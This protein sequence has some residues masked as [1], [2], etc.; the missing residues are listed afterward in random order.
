M[1]TLQAILEGVKHNDITFR[2]TEIRYL[3]DLSESEI[4]TEILKEEIVA[5]E[6]SLLEGE[7]KN[8]IKHLTK[9]KLDFFKRID[10]E[11]MPPFIFSLSNDS[12]SLPMWNTYADNAMGVAIGFNKK[13]L[14][15]VKETTLK[16]CDYHQTDIKNY[17]KKEITNIYNSIMIDNYMIGINGDFEDKL[18]AKFKESV[19][20]LKHHAFE[21]ENESRL[22]FHEIIDTENSEMY[23]N[24]LNFYVNNG[25]LKPY[26][27]FKLETS[28]IEEIVIG[29]CANFELVKTSLFMMLKKVGLNPTFNGIEEG[30]IKITQSKCPFRII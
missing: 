3:N 23:F 24:K 18:W 21:Y 28:A 14:N 16:Q 5:Y 8:I 4:A 30:K 2:A 19:P 13:N 1:A 10:W 17:I 25:L 27:E 29:P 20:I 26:I 12:D 22:V 7:S 6:K 11:K 15:K 9:D